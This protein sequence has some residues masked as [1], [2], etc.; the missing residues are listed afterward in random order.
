MKRMFLQV[1]TLALVGLGVVLQAGCPGAQGGRVLGKDQ[2]AFDKI[3]CYLTTTTDGTV[4]ASDTLV[5]SIQVG[6]AGPGDTTDV[7]KK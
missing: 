5:C 1:A 2:V 7:E 4:T 6:D 3:R